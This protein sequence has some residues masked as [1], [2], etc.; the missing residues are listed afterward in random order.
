MGAGTTGRRPVIGICARTAPVTL[1]GTQMTVSL[2]LQVH[3]DLLTAAG[4]SCVLLPLLPGVEQMVDDID[5]LLIPGG[6]DLDP[7]SYGGAAHPAV[8]GADP[9]TDAAELALVGRVLA[10]G[11]PVVGICRGL[12]VLNVCRGG[13]LHVH[14]PEVIGND[15][16][17]P[18]STSFTLG[19]QRLDVTPGSRIAAIFA[20]AVP[21]TACHHH[22]AV[23]RLGA[24]LVATGHAADGVIEVVEADDHPFAVGVQWEASHGA[25]P[26][27][28][29][30]LVAAARRG[31][32]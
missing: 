10:A 26:R 15:G 2:S 18:E 31:A 9:A 12:Q 30:A 16:H 22:Q 5:A 19:A 6:P 11:R 3:I 1:Q 25:D 4:G 28:H 17:R 23:D 20:E 7:S 24:G 8:R 29:D 27:L 21:E 14:L 13:T 32:A